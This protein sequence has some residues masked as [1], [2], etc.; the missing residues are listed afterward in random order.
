MRGKNWGP[1]TGKEASREIKAQENWH[2]PGSGKR[3][4]G[5]QAYLGGLT[6]HGDWLQIE[7]NMG[8]E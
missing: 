6:G 5:Y 8:S 3:R 2:E 4:D 1:E 7:G